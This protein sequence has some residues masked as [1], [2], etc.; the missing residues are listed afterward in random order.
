M[1]MLVVRVS[2]AE[3][4]VKGE[5]ISSIKEGLAVFA[6]FYCFDTHSDLAAIAEK[7]VNLRVFEDEQAKLNLSLIHI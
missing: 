3:V 2:K 1:R 6:G 4:W 5:N 7:L